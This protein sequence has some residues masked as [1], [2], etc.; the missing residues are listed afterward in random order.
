MMHRIRKVVEN[1]F[2]AWA[3][4]IFIMALLL[5]GKTANVIGT[6]LPVVTP[7]EITSIT[8]TNLP[9]FPSSI[10]TGTSTKLRDCN[11][12]NMLWFIGGGE[13]EGSIFSTFLDRPESRSTGPMT[14]RGIVVGLPPEKIKFARAEVVHDCFGG[15]VRVVSPF[16]AGDKVDR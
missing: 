12:R 7:L 16:F 10:I 3:G 13:K 2:V 15:K 1:G 5:S 8:K 11:Q 14:F 6:L 4:V 9:G